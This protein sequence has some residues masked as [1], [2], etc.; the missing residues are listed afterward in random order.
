MQ[1][2]SLFFRQDIH[3]CYLYVPFYCFHPFYLTSYPLPLPL[4][5][6]GAH[7]PLPTSPSPSPSPPPEKMQEKPQKTKG[8]KSKHIKAKIQRAN[9]INAMDMLAEKIAADILKGI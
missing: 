8:Q 9:K 5:L 1:A 2:P 4:P 7:F 3:R 6:P